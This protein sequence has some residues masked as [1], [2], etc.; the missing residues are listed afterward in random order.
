MFKYELTKNDYVLYYLYV[1]SQDKTNRKKLF[2]NVT[3]FAIVIFFITYPFDE[4]KNEYSQIVSYIIPLL[5]IVFYTY[6][7]YKSF[8]KQIEINAVKFNKDLK[9][10]KI[11]LEFGKSAI[12]VLKE[13]DNYRSE[14][15]IGYKTI[16]EVIETKKHIFIIHPYGVIIIPKRIDQIDIIKNKILEFIKEHNIPYTV[17]LKW[18]WK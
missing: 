3:V 16:N 17:D 6:S 11:E 8:K 13:T 2:I 12:K 9:D 1:S 7:T 18:K 10:M 14:T 4:S 15:N 5:I